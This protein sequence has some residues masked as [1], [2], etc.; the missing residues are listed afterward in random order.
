MNELTAAWTSGSGRNDHPTHRGLGYDGLDWYATR[1]LRTAEAVIL[2]RH[3]ARLGGI[4]LELGCGG[5]RLS[6]HL[7]ALGA[8]VLGLESAPA[9]VEY[10]RAT[11]PSGRFSVRSPLDLHGL[12]AGYDAVVAGSELLNTLDDEGRGEILGAI[13]ELLVAGGIVVMASRNRLPASQPRQLRLTR[14]VRGGRRGSGFRHA[15]RDQQERQ[16]AELGYELLECVDEEGRVVRRG[17]PAASDTELHFVAR[18][19]D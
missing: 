17:D 6:G 2:V 16:L 4:V 7:I 18:R 10:C 14:F 11:Y 13:R 1:D 5:G 15:Y 9:L 8:D 19:V 12:D 3:A